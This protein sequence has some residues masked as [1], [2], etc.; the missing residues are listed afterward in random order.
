MKSSTTE[1]ANHKALSPKPQS[2]MTPASEMTSLHRTGRRLIPAALLLVA[3][4]HRGHVQSAV[5]PAGGPSAEAAWLWW[6]LCGVFAAVFA[7]V[8]VMLAV[9]VFR[10]R[11]ED[12]PDADETGKTDAEKAGAN[13]AGG[14]GTGFIVTAG[15]VVPSVI[16]F[17]LLIVAL[18]S[19]AAM[20]PPAEGPTIRV[21]GHQWWWDVRYPDEGIV[22]ANELHIPVGVPV[23]IELRSAD[24]VHSF[25]VP[26]L[27]GKMDLLP[28]KDNV[29][30]L[31][32]DRPGVFRG[33]CAEY[34]GTQHALMGLEVVALP[35]D[36]YDAWVAERQS[37]PPPAPPERVAELIR[38]RLLFFD[39]GCSKCHAIGETAAIAEKGPDLTHIGSRRTLGAA[40]LPNDSENLEA[41]IVDPHAFKPGN[42]MPPTNLEPA[43]LRALVAYL[44]S[45]K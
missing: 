10:P 8:V 22:T 7:I 4:C 24:V 34:C 45:L 18:R 17:A 39:A 33:Q 44:N 1:T 23:R 25:W 3:G 20:Q 32:A 30:W 5:H 43:D 2:P 19:T 15:V 26:N 13:R 37:D 21:V 16:L 28:E 12:E 35:Q 36:E 9:A 40:V 14:L 38:G 41:W 42:L 27:N 11:D 6:L 29:T 31:Q